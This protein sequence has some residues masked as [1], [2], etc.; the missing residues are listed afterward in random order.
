MPRVQLTEAERTTYRIQRMLYGQMDLKNVRQ[1]DVAEIWD[2][3]TA[4]AGYRINHMIMHP[5]EFVSLVNYLG[6]D[7]KEILEMF[8]RK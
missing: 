4:G 1:K 5:N 2:M 7:D 6:F 3:S 8:G